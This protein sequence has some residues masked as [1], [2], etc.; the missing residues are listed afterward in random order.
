MGT[1]QGATRACA[2]HFSCRVQNRIQIRMPWRCCAVCRR[3]AGWLSTGARVC[4]THFWRGVP[5]QKPLFLSSFYDFA[6]Q[7]V[8]KPEDDCFTA[9]TIGRDGR[10]SAYCV[11]KVER[12]QF[13]EV[14]YFQAASDHSLATVLAS[15]GWQDI[16]LRVCVPE[17][18]NTI[19]RDLPTTVS[20][21]ERPVVQTC[22]LQ[23]IKVIHQLSRVS[24]ARGI[25]R[26]SSPDL[27]GSLWQPKSP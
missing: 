2:Q 16:Y 19:G 3:S 22:E 17:F 5:C 4:L 13:R 7:Y 23:R 9:S 27:A 12:Q 21:Q 8:W 18:F 26:R 15:L 20:G 11:E 10:L 1:C 6:A 25:K 14:P 24:N